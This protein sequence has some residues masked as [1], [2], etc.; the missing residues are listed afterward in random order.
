MGKNT[1]GNKGKL[2]KDYKEHV[3]RNDFS[4]AKV[5]KMYGVYALYNYD[6]LCY[7]GLATNLHKRISVHSRSKHKKWI[8]FS[9][10][11]IPKIKFIKDV[12]TIL[13]RITHP[14]YNKVSGKFH[15]IKKLIVF[16]GI[17][18]ATYNTAFSQETRKAIDYEGT[19]QKVSC[20]TDK[21]IVSEG[22]RQQDF[23]IIWDKTKNKIWVL[24]DEKEYWYYIIV[25]KTQYVINHIAYC[26]Y[27]QYPYDAA[28]KAEY[29]ANAK[30]GNLK[31][32]YSEVEF[33]DDEIIIID[34]STIIEEYYSAGSSKWDEIID[35]Q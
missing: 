22:V 27:R 28:M 4:S 33:L 23:R 6:G 8:N 21:G 13:I 26:G 25:K 7:I 10:Y 15:K 30:K 14:K 19:Q 1:S 18:L 2:V 29:A 12:E 9:W 31:E 11:A 3:N 34:N 5:P 17:T 32:Y 20:I 24:T 35:W 16:L